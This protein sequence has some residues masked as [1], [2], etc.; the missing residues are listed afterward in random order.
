MALVRPPT[1]QT[2]A[3][4]GLSFEK[5]AWIEDDSEP[6]RNPVVESAEFAYQ[7]RADTLRYASF[8]RAVQKTNLVLVNDEGVR[9]AAK[10]VSGVPIQFKMSYVLQ[11]S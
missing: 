7:V 8:H 9:M 3:D 4:D 5:A 2:E 6:Q 1:S 10:H 11:D